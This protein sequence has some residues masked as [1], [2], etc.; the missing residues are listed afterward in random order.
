MNM[1][2]RLTEPFIDV[3][4]VLWNSPQGLHGY[5]IKKLTKRLSPT[6]YNNLDRLTELGWAIGSYELRNPTPGRPPRQ[7]FKLTPEGH[8]RVEE[9]LIRWGR[10]PS[11]RRFGMASDTGG[12]L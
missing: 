4:E 5:E 11:P 6:V 9:L 7:I 8:A 2:E 3:A 12:D 10:I 1:P